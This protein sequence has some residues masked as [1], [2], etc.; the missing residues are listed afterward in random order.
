[1]PKQMFSDERKQKIM[2]LL[3]N[4]QSVKVNELRELFC[5]SEVTIRRD[6]QELD[7]AGMLKRT[8]GGA[9]SI[10]VASFEPNM[11]ERQEENLAEKRAIARAA[12]ELIQDG[13]TILFDAGSTVLLLARFL[14]SNP[15][16]NL[17]VITNALNVAWELYDIDS[18][19]LILTGGQVRKNTLSSIGSIAENT[20]QSLHVN[21]VFLATNSLDIE[22]GLTT[23]NMYEAQVKQKMVK[24]GDKVIVLADH[25]KFGWASLGWICSLSEVHCVVTDL[26]TV[27]EDI[28]ELK[29]LGIETIVA[30]TS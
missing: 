7:D 28:A 11:A 20:I 10:G 18:V 22:R 13:D 29:K 5:V 1:M 23:P 3:D 6:L 27:S 16:K 30:N 14:K 21:K 2:E 12:L 8:H 15:K 24:A 19:D 9:V 26:G 4:N 17:T 25:S